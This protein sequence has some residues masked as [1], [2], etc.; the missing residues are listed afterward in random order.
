MVAT[1][2]VSAR[3][4]AREVVAARLERQAAK[5][6][7]VEDLYA[8]GFK[9]VAGVAAAR[10]AVDAAEQQ[11]AVALA[12]LST[13]G[14]TQQDIGQGL[15]MAAEDVRRLIRTGRETATAAAG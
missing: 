13:E 10:A 1:S 5:N 7:R 3:Q 14:E 12:A 6:K 15:K 11:L 2:E 9:A 8:A 4:R